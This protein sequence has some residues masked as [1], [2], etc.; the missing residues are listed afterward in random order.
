MNAIWEACNVESMCYLF[1][2]SLSLCHFVMGGWEYPWEGSEVAVVVAEVTLIWGE[3]DTC[4]VD[5][6]DEESSFDSLS[7]DDSSFV[8][9]IT[10]F[11]WD[12][13][14]FWT[15]EGSERWGLST[16]FNGEALDVVFFSLSGRFSADEDAFLRRGEP[17]LRGED[18]S[19]LFGVFSNQLISFGLI[20]RE[21]ASEWDDNERSRFD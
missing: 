10:T 13:F 12:A 2:E 16:L 11:F 21:F 7:E 9:E 8:E 5:S 4:S 17:L 14:F 1:F 18:S 6:R 3:C 15:K 20:E 19:D